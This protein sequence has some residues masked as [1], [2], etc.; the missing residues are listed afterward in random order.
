MFL[1]RFLNQARLLFFL[2]ILGSLGVVPGVTVAGQDA[3]DFE[4][5]K[6]YARFSNAAYLG[7]SRID[8]IGQS[9]D[10]SLTHYGDIPK[11]SVAYYLLTNDKDKTQVIA[12]RGT[13]NVENTMLDMDLKLVTDAHAGVRLH[14]GFSLAAERIYREVK[15][16]LKPDYALSTTGHSLGG[17]VALILAMYLDLDQFDVT[18]VVTFGQ[19]KV[20]NIAGAEKF[21][22]LN[23]L[24]VV[25]PRD[26]VPLLP[27]LDYSDIYKLDIYWHIGQEVILLPDN[28]YA[29]LEGVASMLR[30]TDFSKQIP[31]ESN[32]QHH[33]MAYYFGRLESKLDAAKEVPFEVDLNLFNL[34]GNGEQE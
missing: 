10:Y 15:P 22:H 26:M 13:S 34:F 32:L 19:P 11:L 4:L 31:S 3:I 5:V 25:T 8:E 23:I 24:R 7:K 9:S 20:T 30:V 21:S 2:I 33:Q 29:I 18:R 6:D 17:A 28:H 1:L 12:V 14:R 27:P 16:N